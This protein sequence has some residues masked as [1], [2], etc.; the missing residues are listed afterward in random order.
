MSLDAGHKTSQVETLGKGVR[1]VSVTKGSGFRGTKTDK[2][3]T[4]D[5]K[6]GVKYQCSSCGKI[7]LGQDNDAYMHWPTCDRRKTAET[8][9]M[10]APITETAT[11]SPSSAPAVRT[12]TALATDIIAAG[13]TLPSPGLVADV[14]AA[15]TDPIPNLQPHDRDLI[16]EIIHDLDRRGLGRGRDIERKQS[17][18][19]RR[20]I[21]ARR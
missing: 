2:W 11:S 20:F 4:K 9:T 18:A 5:S 15:P 8:G 7:T 10:H 6:Y 17:A 3:W 14:S 12:I 21:G 16:L 19:L 1:I 13:G